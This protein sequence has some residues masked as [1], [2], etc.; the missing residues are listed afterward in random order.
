MAA[1]GPVLRRHTDARVSTPQP[2]RWR[3]RNPAIPLILIERTPSVDR[4]AD[5]DVDDKDRFVVTDEV[6]GSGEFSTVYVGLDTANANAGVA[7]KVVKC[8]TGASADSKPEQR[9]V[10]TNLYM[11]HDNIVRV[12]GNF[13]SNGDLHIVSALAEHGDLFDW[14]VRMCKLLPKEASPLAVALSPPH[15]ANAA[16]VCS[17]MAAGI[18]YAHAA[19]IAH[20]DIK[21]ENVLVFSKD[22]L[23]VKVTDWGLAYRRDIDSPEK[24]RERCG[25]LL[26]AAPELTH[27]SRY[28]SR[29]QGSMEY[30]IDPFAADTWSFGVTT[31]IVAH[32]GLPYMEEDIMSSDFRGYTQIMPAPNPR[33]DHRVYAVLTKTL[34]SYAPARISMEQCRDVFATSTASSVT[35]PSEDS[36]STF[37]DGSSSA[38]STDD[39]DS[40][41]SSRTDAS[42][43]NCFESGKTKSA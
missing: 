34:N 28:A 36:T 3:D 5:S 6:L 29:T 16:S 42:V 27:P 31:Y 11:Q 10:T 32:L 23:R 12:L 7:I 4:I 39:D 35:T 38:S 20:R 25:S 14:V 41:G 19:G 24:K 43:A 1:A 33:I 9:E 13:W 2:A 15:V 21:A 30:D 18:A 22:P 40:S 26:Y 37:D 8:N 17:Q